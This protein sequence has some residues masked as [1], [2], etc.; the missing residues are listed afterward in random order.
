MA[1]PRLRIQRGVPLRRPCEWCPDVSGPGVR[2]VAQRPAGVHASGAAW[3]WDAESDGLCGGRGRTLRQS[4]RSRSQGR[5][6]TPRNRVRRTAVWSRGPRWPPLALLEA[7]AGRESGGVGSYGGPEALRVGHSFS[8]VDLAALAQR[9]L[10]DAQHLCFRR[11]FAGPDLELARALLHKHFQP[12]DY[13]E[14]AGF[15]QLEQRS[16]QR[17]VDHVEDQAD[18]QLILLNGQQLL[19]ARHAARR[20]VDERVELVLR[21]QLLLRRLGMRLARQ[22]HRRIMCAVDDKDLCSLLNQAEDSSARRSACAQ[23][24]DARTLQ[25]HP[26]FERP[27]YTGYVGV[28]AIDF[29][30]RAGAQR[31]AGSDAGGQRVHVGQVRQHFLLERHGDGNAAQR[32]ITH[33]GQQIVKHAHLQGQHYRV[34]TLAAEGRIVHQRR[35]RVA[36]GIAG[37]TEDARRLVQLLQ[38]VEVE[39]RP[40]GNLS[41]RCFRPI[42][43]RGKGERG[44]GARPEHTAYQPL[45]AHGDAHHV[46]RERVVFNQPQNCKIVCEGPRRR[47][48]LYEI[49]LEGLDPGCRLFQSLGPGKVVEADQQRRPCCP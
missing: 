47:N 41:C 18:V 19:D 21:Q 32:E 3:L 15:R 10:D 9:Q 16:V 2:Y 28:E 8:C 40:D 13:R 12:T 4:Q 20:G 1:R 29:T 45:L 26:L 30:V 46:R 48:H 24:Y 33:Y 23:N 43:R 36:N 27:H 38:A 22:R 7:R 39:Q 11:G 6:G 25:A 49:R 17:V 35:E 44:P 34:H 14:A 31:V 37:H 5:R 42:F